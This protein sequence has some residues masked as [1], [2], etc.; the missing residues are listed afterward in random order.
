MSRSTI[1]TLP[2]AI[3]ANT[4]AVLTASEVVPDP[5]LAEAKAMTRPGPAGRQYLRLFATSHGATWGAQQQRLDKGFQLAPVNGL[6]N[7]VVRAGFQEA[8]AGF[9]VWTVGDGQDRRM[10]A[11][12]LV[13]DAPAEHRHGGLIGRVE[14]HELVLRQS[15][16][17]NLR[18]TSHGDFE[19]ARLEARHNLVGDT[20]VNAQKKHSRCQAPTSSS[21]QSATGRAIAAPRFARV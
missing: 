9:H 8:H 16:Q 14:D 7:N 17:G 1:A 4:R 5:P 18:I 19:A 2:G 12:G 21:P 3:S 10:G 20:P 13:V 11:A 15:A 6:R